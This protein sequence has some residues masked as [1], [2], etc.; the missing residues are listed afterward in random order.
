MDHSV[1]R[2]PPRNDLYE[3]DFYE[4]TQEQA[5]LLRERRWD[6]LDVENLIEEVASVGRSDKNE[7]RSRL[8]ILLAH[9]LK[10]QYQPGYRSPSWTSTLFEQRGRIISIIEDSPSLAHY[11][12]EQVT[13]SYMAAR[14]LA[15]KETGIAFGLFPE[16]CPFPP[17]RVLDLQ[18]FPEDRSIE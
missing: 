15:A 17:D 9:L 4:W 16:E 1:T 6:D 13:R 11:P 10:W 18:Y 14:L 3:A 5:R 7:I 2:S 8:E 12:A